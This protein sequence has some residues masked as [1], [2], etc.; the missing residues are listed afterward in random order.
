[1]IKREVVIEDVL[2]EVA[3]NLMCILKKG[4][5]D[6][7]EEQITDHYRCRYTIDFAERTIVI[8]LFLSERDKDSVLVAKV[9]MDK[10]NVETAAEAACLTLKI[11]DY[12][13]NIYSYV[14][15][16]DRF[17]KKKKGSY[18]YR[19]WDDVISLNKA[20]NI[21]HV[22]IRNDDE[23]REVAEFDC[24]IEDGTD[25]EIT[26]ASVAAAIYSHIFSL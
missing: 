25:I 11:I 3:C 15:K 21:V 22:K 23:T 14:T 17:L 13:N 4:K 26:T 18:I 8:D 12:A 2:P 1:M 6:I 9:Q 10:C 24:I 20:G 5:D 19:F 16:I 7:Y